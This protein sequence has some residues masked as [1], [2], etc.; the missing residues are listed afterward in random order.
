MDKFNFLYQRNELHKNNIRYTFIIE[1][2][3]SQK[4]FKWCKSVQSVEFPYL[5]FFMELF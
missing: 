1:P 3:S 4:H 5:N 2:N